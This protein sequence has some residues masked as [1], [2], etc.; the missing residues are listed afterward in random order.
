V[1]LSRIV[2]IV[3]MVGLLAACGDQAPPP[4][5]DQSAAPGSFTAHLP[6]SATF[7]VGTASSR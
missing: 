4:A 6:G 2:A 1:I 5:S 7:F 3:L